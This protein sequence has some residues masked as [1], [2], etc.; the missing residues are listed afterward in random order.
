MRTR[1]FTM[2]ALSLAATPVMARDMSYLKSKPY[3]Q[4]TAGEISAAK[5][6]A[7]KLKLTKLVA[8]ADPGNMPLSNDKLEGFQNKIAAAVGAKLG[9]DITF[10]WRPYL[11]RGLTR[12]TFD[13]NEC[14]VLIDLPSDYSGILMTQPIY[15]TAY[16]LAYREDSGLD[17]KSINDP[18]L[19]N[20]RV[21]VFQQSA[22]REALAERGMKEKLDVQIITS[23]A[24]LRPE[25]QP[26]RQVQRVVDK[27]LDVAGVWGPFAGWLKKQGAPLVVQPV[28]LDA[29]SQPLEFSLAWGV[30]NTD[31]VLKLKIDMAL[32]E[33][34]SEI[35]AIL[36][37]YG[38]PLV[39]CSSCVVEGNLPSMGTLEKARA[40]AYEKRFTETRQETKLSE[41]ASSDQVVSRERLEKW[42][43][44]GANVQD[45]LFN[46]IAAGDEERVALLIDKK[47]DVNKRDGLGH[48][49]LGLA[50]S[51]RKTNLM[52]PLL[53]AGALVDASDGDEMTALAHAINAN[54]VPSIELLAKSGADIEKGTKA[55]YTALELALVDGKFFAA[56]ALIDAGAKVDTASG[57]EQVTPLMVLATLLQPQQRLNQISMGP[58]PLV[59]AE[60]LL[61]RKVDVNARSKD[62]VTALMIAA[63]HNNAPMIGLLLRAG[64]DA[65]LKASNG[66]TALDIAVEA[67]NEAAVGALKFLAGSPP[68]AS[69]GDGTASQ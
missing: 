40:V 36:Q 58:T 42:L 8:C 49:P 61:K 24:D 25:N 6:E 69:A 44:D 46:A 12:D 48:L 45:E 27:E 22:L 52:G 47:A 54:H 59:L 41:K 29:T 13:N 11:E 50:A 10:F 68:R 53:K 7:K 39:Q 56:K 37:D 15:R 34:R 66:K 35:A 60:E 38:V 19:L 55:G 43:A 3:D 18:R 63:G 62:G 67:Q 9:T 65:K 5:E 33:A 26:W 20:L 28:N 21:G 14:Q 2:L 1:I 4:L 23:D 64:A 17:I 32:D 16:V 31:V 57:P 30:Q 51:M